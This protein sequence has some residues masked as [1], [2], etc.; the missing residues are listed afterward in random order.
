MQAGVAQ[1]HWAIEYEQAAAEAFKLNYPEAKVFCDNCNVLL[2]VCSQ[3]LHVLSRCKWMS[4]RAILT[5]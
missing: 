3:C 1:S 5:L 4:S 2:M